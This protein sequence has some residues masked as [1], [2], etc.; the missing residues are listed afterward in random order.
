MDPETMLPQGFQLYEH[1]HS[2]KLIEEFML[3][4]NS[5]VAKKIAL[6]F[7]NQAM[8]RR[9]PEPKQDVMEGTIEML[10]QCGMLYALQVI[11]W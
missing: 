8:L 3:L 9:H 7:P 11:I 6:E 1:R 2:N 5:A 4:A 10:K